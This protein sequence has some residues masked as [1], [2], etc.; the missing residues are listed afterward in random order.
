MKLIKT[1]LPPHKAKVICCVIILVFQAAFSL[2]MPFF[3]GRLIGV[4]IQQKGVG[5]MPPEVIG[6][7]L[8]QIFEK[9]LPDEA[10]GEFA[11]M[12]ERYDR[13][14]EGKPDEFELLRNCYYLKDGAD[15]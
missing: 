3:M 6:N 15:K 14:P 7:N 9:V 5:D 11:S 8:L 1:Y 2:A 4:G 12:Y 10:Y 13:C